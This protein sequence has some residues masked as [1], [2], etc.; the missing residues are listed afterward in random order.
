MQVGLLARLELNRG[1]S[2][3]CKRPENCRRAFRPDKAPHQRQDM[4]QENRS[5]PFSEKTIWTPLL[6]HLYLYLLQVL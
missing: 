4:L 3:S 1:Q 6:W 2:R 5:D